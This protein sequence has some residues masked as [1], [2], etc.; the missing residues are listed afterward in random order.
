MNGEDGLVDDEQLNSLDDIQYFCIIVGG[1]CHARLARLARRHTVSLYL[2]TVAKRLGKT[3][4]IV[5]WLIFSRW[6]L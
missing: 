6:Y 1:T 3:N 5:A 4:Q 2:P